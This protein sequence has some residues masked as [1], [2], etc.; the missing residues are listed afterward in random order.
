[1]YDDKYHCSCGNHYCETL[2]CD[3]CKEDFVVSVSEYRSYC[4]LLCRR[5]AEE[6]R[7]IHDMDWNIMKKC[8]QC[9]DR[10]YEGDGIDKNFCSHECRDKYHPY[11]PEYNPKYEVDNEDY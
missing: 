3:F 6:G 7:T 10:Y 4:S 5:M 1:M 8:K 11:Y 9:G 2:T